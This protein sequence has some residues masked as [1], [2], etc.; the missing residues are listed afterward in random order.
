MRVAC[1]RVAKDEAESDGFKS[2]QVGTFI[3]NTRDRQV[4]VDN[5]L[6]DQAGNRCGSNMLNAKNLIGNGQPDKIPYLLVVG[7][8]RSLV[9]VKRSGL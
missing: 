2:W 3:V 5:R 8:P 4:N 7:C 9:L 6:C 1:H